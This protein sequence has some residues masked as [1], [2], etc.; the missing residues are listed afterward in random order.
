MALDGLAQEHIDGFFSAEGPL[1]RAVNQYEARKEQ[2]EVANHVAASIRDA[3]SL[4]AEAGTGTGKTLAYLVP[5]LASGL[6]VVLS[7]GTRNLQEQIINGCMLVWFHI[8]VLFIFIFCVTA[9]VRQKQVI[10]QEDNRRWCY[11]PGECNTA[12]NL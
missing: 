4:V 1:A 6:R 5:A 9:A 8:V 10:E 2:V 3:Q 11:G 12:M 7:T